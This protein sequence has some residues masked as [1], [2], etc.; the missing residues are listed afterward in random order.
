MLISAVVLVGQGCAAYQEADDAEQMDDAATIETEQAKGE[1]SEEMENGDVQSEDKATDDQK[2]TEEV[3]SESGV[4]LSGSAQ[5][6]GTVKFDWAISSDLSERAEGFRFAR[7]E[8]ENPTYPASWWWERGP[9]H[10][11]LIWEGLPDG[12]AH[13]RLCVVENDVC[14]VYS[15]DVMISVPGN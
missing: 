6:K 12:D 7:G 9:A 15:N 2:V 5:G 8:E 10:R 11:N 1:F 13:F 14:T 4:T 3:L